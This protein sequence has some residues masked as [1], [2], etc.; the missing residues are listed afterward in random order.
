MF[1]NQY[2]INLNRIKVYL[3]S[4]DVT[5]KIAKYHKFLWAVRVDFRSVGCSS[6]VDEVPSLMVPCWSCCVEAFVFCCKGMK[7]C[8]RTF[9]SHTLPGLDTCVVLAEDF[10][11]TGML[12]SCDAGLLSASMYAVADSKSDETVAAENT[13]DAWV[14]KDTYLQS[15]VTVHTK[16]PRQYERHFHVARYPT[17]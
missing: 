13:V 5:L 11:F 8:R 15:T 4:V 1:N 7:L 14:L 10:L 3:K 16:S 2:S 6:C 17:L 12:L 9:F